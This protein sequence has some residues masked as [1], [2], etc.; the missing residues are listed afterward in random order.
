MKSSCGDIALATYVDTIRCERSGAR[1]RRARGASPAVV[2]SA[3][4]YPPS[5]RFGRAEKVRAAPSRS[6]ACQPRYDELNI[7]EHVS[8]NNRRT[9]RPRSLRRN[10]R[11]KP[12]PADT[13]VDVELRA[14]ALF[15]TIVFP[16]PPAAPGRPRASLLLMT[17]GDRA[18]TSRTARP[19]ARLTCFHAIS[20]RNSNRRFF[21][22]EKIETADSQ[23]AA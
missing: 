19:L 16:F 7:A 10:D 4:L 20:I 2:Q 5:E 22:H 12:R 23:T 18:S 13:E 1:W 21:F 9:E 17:A 15:P 8:R 6:R 11:R 3:Y 14:H